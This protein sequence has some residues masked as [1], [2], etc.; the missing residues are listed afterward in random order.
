VRWETEWPFDGKL[1]Q[2]YSYQKLSKSDSCRDVNETR[3]WREREREREQLNEN[4]NENETK[5]HE[6]ENENEN[7]RIVKFYV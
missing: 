5:N 2:K 3:L 1:C 4:E 6:N 7:I